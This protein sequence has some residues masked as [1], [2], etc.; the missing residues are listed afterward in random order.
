MTCCHC[1]DN[2][3]I[4]PEFGMHIARAASEL[5]ATLMDINKQMYACVV[6][7]TAM[8]QNPAS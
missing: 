3:I 4:F 1:N 5:S 2:R 6:V 8:V 7:K